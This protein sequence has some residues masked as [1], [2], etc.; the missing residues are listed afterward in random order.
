MRTH[1]G[2]YICRDHYKT[3]NEMQYHKCYT[4]T[5]RENMHVEW[6]SQI[7]LDHVHIHV[8]TGKL[9]QGKHTSV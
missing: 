9:A 8:V 2:I 1:T 4:Y 7:T 5:T 3:L 6:R